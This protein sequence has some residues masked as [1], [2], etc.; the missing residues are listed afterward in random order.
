MIFKEILILHLLNNIYT[1]MLK[2]R[3]QV[4]T[5]LQNKKMKNMFG[6]EIQKLNIV[7][8]I[9]KMIQNYNINGNLYYKNHK[10]IQRLLLI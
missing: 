3:I 8:L 2:V 7:K 6:G 10:A 1:V 9:Q 5:L 4:S